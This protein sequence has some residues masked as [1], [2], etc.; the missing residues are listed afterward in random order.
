MPALFLS[1]RHPQLIKK[2]ALFALLF[3]L[4]AVFLMDYVMH[5][6]HGWAIGEME[7][8]AVWMLE[9]ISLLN[10][11]WLFLYVYLVVMYYEAFFDRNTN[12]VIYP[13]TKNLI[14]I[15]VIV[16]G[17]VTLLHFFNREFLSIDYFYLKVGLGAVILP[18]VV[19]WFRRRHVVSAKFLQVGA[20]FFGYNLLY[21]L[22]ALELNQWS[23][24]S[25]EQF[26]GHVSL[27]GHTFPLEEFLFWIVLSA[28]A[29]LAHYEYFNDDER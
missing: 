27:M 12:K 14:I 9:Y 18:L 1:W 3:S 26:I 21:E 25:E 4:P 8:R 6:T 19:F 29:I 22:T 11:I 23:F 13:R 16:I 28:M 20:Y 15:A 5:Y 24:P 7:F 17:A 10:I 2:S